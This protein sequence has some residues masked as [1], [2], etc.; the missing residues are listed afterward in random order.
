MIVCCEDGIFF[1]LEQCGRSINVSK[2][3]LPLNMLVKFVY[4]RCKCQLDVLFSIECS[5]FDVNNATIAWM[6]RTIF[7]YCLR[8][9]TNCNWNSISQCKYLEFHLRSINSYWPSFAEKEVNYLRFAD[10][11]LELKTKEFQLSLWRLCPSK[12]KLQ[13][14]KI[15][16]ISIME[17]KSNILSIKCDHWPSTCFSS[18]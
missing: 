7:I 6:A 14:L 8:E 13:R 10:L 15:Q 3:I 17:S 16:F 9:H 4:F 12:S 11:Q 5:K 18:V 2:V 1:S